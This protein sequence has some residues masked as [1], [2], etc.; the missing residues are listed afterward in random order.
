MPPPIPSS[1]PPPEA[2]DPESSTW[3]TYRDRLQHFFK[4]NRTTDPAEKKSL[5]LW[6]IGSITYQLLENL[7]SPRSIDDEDSTL[8]HLIRTL[9]AH[10][11]DTKNIM[12]STYDF[13]SCLQKDGQS[14]IDWKAE[15]CKKLRHCGFTTS[16][17]KD[18]PQERALRDMFVIGIRNPKIRQAL[19]KEQDPDLEKAEKIIVAAERL[20]EDV[21]HFGSPSPR[22]TIPIANIQHQ[23][24][25]RPFHHPYKNDNI[26]HNKCA[27]C[28]S[29]EHTRQT[30]P[31]RSYTCNS[32]KRPGHLAKVCRSRQTG[33]ENNPSVKHLTTTIFK[34]NHAD[35]GV[36]SHI[37]TTAVPLRI[38]G[39]NCTFELDTGAP[40][41]IISMKDWNNLG[42]PNL[43]ASNFQLKSFGGT[44]IR[45]KG[46]C[47]VDV[48]YKQQKFNLFAI[49]VNESGPSLL[50]LQWMNQLHLDLNE[51]VYGQNYTVQ[52]V[53]KIQG[54]SHLQSILQKHIHV[55]NNELGHCT[56][57]KA[58]I[59]LKPDAS[60]R[61]YRPRSIPLAYIDGV[62]A[63]IQRNVSAGILERI[64]TSTWAAPIV[65]VKKPNGSIRICG[66]FKVT[67]NPQILVDQHPIP[68]IDELLAR[69]ENGE[70]FTKLDLSDAYLQVE[71]DDLSKNLVVINTPLGLFR[72]TRM[73][74]GIAN[75]PAIFQRIIDQLIAGIPKCAA[76]LDDILITGTNEL[77]H[78]QTLELVLSKL[79]DFGFKCNPAKCM[80]FQDEVSYLGYVIDKHGKRPD[81]K[82]V[83][84]IVKMPIP[85]NVKEMEAFIGKVNYYNKFISNFSN[86]CKPLN[87]LR[88]SNVKWHWND[89][90]QEAFDNL[91]QE[92]SSVTILVHFDSKL[93]IIL[94]TDASN[95]GLGAVIM[96]RYP[97]G[98][99]YPIAHASKTLT[100]AEKNYSQIEKE[101]FSIVYGVKKF[102]QYL[103]GRS[104]ELNTD[105][106]PL[107]TIFNPSKGLP[108]STANRL[109]RWAIFL[110]GYTYTIRYKS[111]HCHANADG[112]S[113]LPAGP[114]DSFIDNDAWQIN[115]IQDKL[116]EQWPIRATEIAAATDADEILQLVKQ[117]TLTKW[118]ASVSKS[119]NPQLIPFYASR[120]SISVVQGC[121]LRDTQLIIPRQLR[122]RILRLLHKSHLGPVK[123]KQLARSH[124]WWPDIHKDIVKLSQSCRI[125]S[126]LH[127][128]PPQTF[129]QWEEPDMVW[130]RVHM[131]F[132]GPLWNSKW[133][134]LVDAKSKFPFVFD[135]KNDTTAKNLCNAL[136]TVIDW[137]GPPKTLV[138]DNGP[139]FTSHEMKNFYGKYG[140]D[141]ITTPPYHPASNGVA[142]RFVRTFK[143]TILKERESKHLDKLTALRN[144]LR[145]YRWSPHTSTGLSPAEMMFQHTIRTEFEMMKPVES[146]EVQQTSKYAIGDP[147]WALDYRSN[148]Q[149]EWQPAT[150]TNHLGSMIYEIQSPDGQYHK[151]HQN[152]LRRDYT[153]DNH[154]SD[155][156]S[157]IDDS[158]SNT[159]PQDSIVQSPNQ[160]SP[161][162]PRRNRKPPDRYTPT[163]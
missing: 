151:R 137:F 29:I 21:Q 51:I 156:E 30:C 88:Q 103:A 141:H 150:V 120:Y 101:A 161:R 110:M 104:F 157:L 126:Q 74:F 131:D 92:I 60:P 153:Q 98:S 70:K 45:I 24:P 52:S 106:Q 117:Y 112:L 96:H 159:M 71:L 67:I 149:Y 132:V 23:Q 119:N 41:T 125:C 114:D 133:L 127:S 108:V 77:E 10:Y 31:Y 64:D 20:Y 135:M 9:D 130:C 87:N 58:H 68:S 62:K 94:A 89:E 39:H 42:S 75:A 15:L 11:D 129:K 143:E 136:E 14:F 72:Y 49:V 43:R 124:C 100:V 4:A 134:I 160:S 50:G 16:T 12:T 107:L 37:G 80:F 56:K 46:E 6:Y 105:H 28:G 54:P 93:P 85:Q 73:P 57:V 148:R 81:P 27:S 13:Y 145:S 82:R 5:F 59:E 35:Q 66:D 91:R 76:Y 17:L 109:Q 63:E 22:V 97:D 144:V 138:S 79:A 155:L 34:L 78:L 26:D 113:R 47:E 146:R 1:I 121:L 65:P 7:L 55:L 163:K 40:H 25:R 84:A 44:S 32:C 102:H 111:T 95:H 147:V 154:L 3:K 128:K 158:P 53:N 142:E 83:E 8:E 38:N 162:Y 19:L 18:K 48:E 115:Y 123:M 140:I 61:F 139:P 36:Q 69:L 99:E 33:K 152:Q 90:C 116:I 86:K 122:D 118:P 2:F